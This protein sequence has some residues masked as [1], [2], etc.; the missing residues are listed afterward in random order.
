MDFLGSA[1]FSKAVQALDTK[2]GM[3]VCLKIIKNNKDYFDQSLDE[4]KLLKY[5]SDADPDDEHG[6]LRLYDYFY[7]KEHLFLVCE[8]L[9][10]NLYEFQKYNR[11]N[12]D[13]LYFTLP[14]LQ[15]IAH[16]VLRSIAFMHSLGLIHSDLKPENILIKSYS[17]CE[18]KVIDLGSSCFVTDHLSSYVQSRS[19]RAPEVILGLPYDQKVDIWSFGCILAE[20]LTGLVLFQNDSLATLLARLEGILG[21]VPQWMIRKGRY[22]HRYYTR[23]GLIYERSSSTGRYEFLRPKRTSLR[24]RLHNVDQGFVDFVSSL[25]C[26]DPHLRPTAEQA[27]QHPWLQH[28]YP[29][30]NPN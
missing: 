6:M 26:V 19:Y 25:L 11:D 15:K 20:L 27:L 3:L 24:Q 29:P 1:A 17:R 30:L 21:E 13:E 5:V 9:R 12:G 23:Q 4:I 22:S 10:A 2:T 18:V 7:Y 8:L 14:R 28:P 16:Q